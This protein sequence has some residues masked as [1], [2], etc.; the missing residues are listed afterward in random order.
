MEMT[1]RVAGEE[2]GKGIK[3]MATATRVA[4]ERTAMA[5]KRVM[6]M[7]ARL[8]GAGEGNDQPLC[9]TQQ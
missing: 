6:A 8:G 3:A 2:E 9:T 7:K 4:G 1:M 5:T